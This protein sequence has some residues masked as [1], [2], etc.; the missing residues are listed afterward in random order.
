MGAP[1]ERLTSSFLY[2]FPSSFSPD[3][4]L[5]VFVEVDPATAQDVWAL[6]LDQG[7]KLRPVLRT[8]SVEDGPVFSPDGQWLA[9]VSNE[10]GDNAVYVRRFSGS[11]RK[12]RISAGSG[13]EVA[14]APD[15]H[16][17]FYRSGDR[18][19]AV[20]IVTQ[21]T[22]RAGKPH[23]LFERTFAKGGPWRNYDVSRDGHRFLMLKPTNEDVAL[24][25][26]NVVLNWFEEV[27]K[28]VPAK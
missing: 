24:T 26:M 15:G 23:L 7:R 10:S 5:L 17:L 11:G 28:R 14:W 6:P 22:L 4:R 13:Q 16:E 3:G 21:P 20:D 19:M 25:Q 12:I 9:F 18:M 27:S 1:A 8:Q 2:Q